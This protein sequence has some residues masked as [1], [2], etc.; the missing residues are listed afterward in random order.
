MVAVDRRFGRTALRRRPGRSGRAD[1]RLCLFFFMMASNGRAYSIQGETL[2][3]FRTNGV[4]M[5]KRGLR[6]IF[7]VVRW[8][9]VPAGL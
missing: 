6:W 9:G 7:L 3:A 4:S 8:L 2:R 1:L 5:H